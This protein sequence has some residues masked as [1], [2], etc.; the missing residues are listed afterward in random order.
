M[1]TAAYWHLR[2]DGLIEC[3]LCPRHCRIADGKRGLCFVRKRIGDEL[4]AE[5]YGR[6]CGLAVDPIEKK[7]LRHFL[8]GSRVLS[9]GTVGCNLTCGFCQNFHLS[10][11]QEEYTRSRIRDS[12]NGREAAALCGNDWEERQPRP[13]I[14]PEGIA[15]AAVEPGCESVAFTYNEPTVFFEYAVDTAKV[16]RER[17]LKTVAVTNG[18][19]EEKPRNEFFSHMDAANVDLKAFTDRFYRE[20]CGASLQ[21]VLDTLIYLRQETDVHL[22][23][24]TLLI[25]GWN[26]SP[27]EIDAMTK[28]A[29]ANLGTD[30]PWHFSAYRPTPHWNEAPPTPLDTLLQAKRIAEAN[31]LRHIHLGNIALVSEPRL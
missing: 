18:W 28:W 17:G 9:F 15:A 8:P 19:I 2:T 21:P 10:R 26:D 12:T 11:A 16:V 25:P 3:T 27:A 5:S 22:E 31:G 24:T 1:K 30:V 29:V 6:A 20:L 13:T 4:I 23:V 14:D 7:P